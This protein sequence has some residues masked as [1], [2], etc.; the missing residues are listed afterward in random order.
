VE[1]LE[2]NEDYF[3]KKFE[4]FLKDNKWKAEDFLNW[5]EKSKVSAVRLW[6]IY[7]KEDFITV[8]SLKILSEDFILQ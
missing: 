7:I 8:F 5:R 1:P 4:D 2:T 6:W 3:N